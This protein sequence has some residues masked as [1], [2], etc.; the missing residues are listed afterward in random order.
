[1]GKKYY[2]DTSDLFNG[3]DT[4]LAEMEYGPIVIF[5]DYKF[6]KTHVLPQ[7]D[8]YDTEDFVLRILGWCGEN[9]IF[10]LDSDGFTGTLKKY[11]MSDFTVDVD[12]LNVF[13]ND[14]AF[15]CDSKREAI[16]Y[17]KRLRKMIEKAQDHIFILDQRVIDRKYI[18]YSHDTWL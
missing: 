5:D 6:P 12:N 7:F 18:K 14:H 8:I 9:S 4:I 1:M 16:N 15:T 17:A 13:V 3:L 11:D 2:R 10:A